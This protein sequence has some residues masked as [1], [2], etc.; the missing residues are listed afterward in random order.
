MFTRII[1]VAI[2]IVFVFIG[3]EYAVWWWKGATAK[4]DDPP[5]VLTEDTC[6]RINGKE[7]RLPQGLVL[8]PLNELECGPEVYDGREFKIYVRTDSLKFRKLADA[9]LDDGSNL[10]HRLWLRDE[11]G[12]QSACTLDEENK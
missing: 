9:E 12:V 11:T 3:C 2:V 7:S 5:I 6:I 8:Y 4:I 10:I 1:A